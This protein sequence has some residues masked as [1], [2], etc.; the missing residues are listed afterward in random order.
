M[1]EMPPPLKLG[2][3]MADLITANYTHLTSSANVLGCFNPNN[4][5]QC[6]CIPDIDISL[7]AYIRY[8]MPFY[9]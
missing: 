6:H 3:K 4:V 9:T 5:I 1:S 2:I 8:T 7:L